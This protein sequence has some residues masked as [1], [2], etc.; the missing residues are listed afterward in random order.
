M[1][2]VGRGVPAWSAPFSG[3]EDWVREG[4]LLLWEE[5]L[6]ELRSG[7]GGGGGGKSCHERRRGALRERRR[8]ELDDGDDA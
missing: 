5:D 2:G 8:W 1:P 6:E 4:R 3:W 7:A